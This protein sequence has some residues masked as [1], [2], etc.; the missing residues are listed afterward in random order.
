MEDNNNKNNGLEFDLDEIMAEIDK[1]KNEAVDALDKLDFNL[2]S[3][4]VAES[5]DTVPEAPNFE[6]KP[7]EP[8][9]EA[10]AE[11][12][13]VLMPDSPKEEAPKS[14]DFDMAPTPIERKE[15]PAD[16]SLSPEPEKE[17]PKTADFNMSASTKEEKED[18]LESDFK[19]IDSKSEVERSS[20]EYDKAHDEAAGMKV[21]ETFQPRQSTPSEGVARA[22]E[23]RTVSLR[24]EGAIPTPRPQVQAQATPGPQAQA[25]PRPQAQAQPTPR[26][27]VQATPRPQTQTQTPVKPKKEKKY[28]T[29]GTLIGCMIL[30][31]FLSTLLG[32]MLGGGLN[33]VINNPAD[34]RAERN[35]S[36]LSQLNLSDA[37]GSELTVAQIVDKNENAVV[38]I[39]VSGTTQGMW[40]QMQ[41]VQGAGSG[42]IMSEDGYI[43]TNY[44]VIQGASKV[45]VTLKNGQVYPARIVG[46]DPSNDVS[47]IKIEDTGLT[48]AE[49]GDS[50]TVDVGDLAVAIGNPLGQLGG[51]A[52]SGIISALDRTLSVEGTTLTLLQTDAAINGGNSG[53]GLFNSRGELIG[54]VESKASAVGVEGLAFALPINTVA[55]IINDIIENG[56]NVQTAGRP[57]VGIQ[58]SD[59]TEEV[60][61]YYGLEEPGVYIAHVTGFNAQQAG[62][63]EQDRIVS[64]NGTKINNS[65]EFIKLVS[66]C[67]VGDTVT[68]VV[69]R[70]GQEIE[71]KTV[72]EEL[73]SEQ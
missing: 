59:V 37:T 33:S 35:D 6:L 29:L 1:S 40:G 25:T 72:L 41:L 23:S 18:L 8:K 58:I 51:T 61:E 16:F 54:I 22:T 19:G 10:P 3:D 55:G 60:S 65:S 68:V 69:S 12:N 32:S 14:D 45:Q 43:A 63:Q 49:I 70:Q 20:F 9:A 56:G 53:G 44:H 13:F 31:M 48:A 71:I 2:A 66:D 39:T 24:P 62:F 17:E 42:V 50:S 21:T 73:Q 64:F 11:P 57:V 28:V 4:S 5:E 30:T 52:T 27:Q 67:K 26:S 38:E 36:E 7:E 47:V 46:S 34:N 15:A